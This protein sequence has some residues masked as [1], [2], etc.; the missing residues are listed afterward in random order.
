MVT[1][2]VGEAP[3]ALAGGEPRQIDFTELGPQFHF[4]AL[5]QPEQHARTGADHLAQRR[6]SALQ[7]LQIGAVTGD[8]KKGLAQVLVHWDNPL[9]LSKLPFSRKNMR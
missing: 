4:A 7:P 1:Q 6:E 9:R 8:R 2:E 5:G 3:D